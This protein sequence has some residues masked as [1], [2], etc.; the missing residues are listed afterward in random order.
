[1]GL[2]LWATAAVTLKLKATKQSAARIRCKNEINGIVPPVLMEAARPISG[3]LWDRIGTR[4]RRF[5]PAAP[6]MLAVKTRTLDPTAA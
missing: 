4:M 5:L 3:L 1:L 2:P 6:A